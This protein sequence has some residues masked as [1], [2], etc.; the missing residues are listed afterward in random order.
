MPAGP[1]TADGVSAAMVAT[2]K[3]IAS[4]LERGWV[5]EIGGVVATVSEIPA[6]TLNGVWAVRAS[7]TAQEMIAGLDAVAEHGLPHSLEARPACA[8]AAATVARDRGLVAADET[9]LMAVAHPAGAPGPHD[10]VVRELTPH[11]AGL[12]WDVA[13][14]AFDAPIEF[15]AALVTPRVLALPEVR[16]YV[17]EVAGVP[18]ATAMSATVG[19]GVGLFNI[20]TAAA[21][22][23]RG[24]GAAVTARA[25]A[26][27]LAAGAS[28]AWLRAGEEGR[29][30]YE[31]LGFSTL[32]RWPSWVTPA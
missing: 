10:L 26:D 4:A 12:H 17:G 16:G 30:V 22:R 20:A 18:V 13:A 31:A 32:E 29:G 25:V 5:R 3:V 6:P 15:F 28:W 2:T 21:H 19:D 7:A 23:R 8:A 11:E 27:G 9:A 1:P 24:Y 14:P